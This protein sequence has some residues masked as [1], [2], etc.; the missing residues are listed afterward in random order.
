MAANTLRFN[1]DNLQGQAEK[2]R[3]ISDDL[4]NAKVR[5][6]DNLELLRS[7]WV[8]DA[9]EAFFSTYDTTWVT[10]ID[11]Y[12]Q[13]LNELSDILLDVASQ[14]EPLVDEYNSIEFA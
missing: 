8:S 3:S 1:L 6:S 12:C 4:N 10:Y 14:Y 13:W 9:S 11:Q 2:I 5:L 7:N